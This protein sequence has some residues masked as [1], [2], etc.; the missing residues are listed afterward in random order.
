MALRGV[1]VCGLGGVWGLGASCC[2]VIDGCTTR[3]VM[4]VGGS[5]DAPG[6]TAYTCAARGSVEGVLPCQPAFAAGVQREGPQRVMHLPPGLRWLS[7][8]VHE[9]C[10]RARCVA[11]E[12]SGRDVW[13]LLLCR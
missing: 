1:K 3:G 5:V 11:E 13:E 10:T 7:R 6:A 4:H 12:K 8:R 2:V 9:T